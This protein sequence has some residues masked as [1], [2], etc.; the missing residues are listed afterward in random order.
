[1]LKKVRRKLLEKYKG[2]GRIPYKFPFSI[3]LE[4]E[5]SG[6]RIVQQS[7]RADGIE[8]E[9]LPSGSYRGC[10]QNNMLAVA[11]TTTVRSW[12]HRRKGSPSEKAAARDANAS[13]RSTET[14]ATMET[15]GEILLNF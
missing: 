6:K 4:R 11:K 15:Q 14:T 10:P 3:L 5:R 9:I 7:A 13:C 2:P 8:A 1:L 12:P